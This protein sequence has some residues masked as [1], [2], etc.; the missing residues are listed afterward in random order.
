MRK[1]GERQPEPEPEPERQPEP[2]P[3]PQ[4]QPEPD[5]ESDAESD[6]D[7]DA[8]SGSGSGSESGA[9]AGTG[10]GERTVEPLVVARGLVKHFPVGGG[11]LGRTRWLRA[12]DGVSFEVGRGETVALVGESGSGK[13]TAGRLVL[14]LLEAT[15]GE[16]FFDGEPIFSAP[17]ARLRELRREMQ[18]IFQ[19]PFGSLNPRHTVEAI[20]GEGL[21]TK[22]VRSRR[23]RRDLAAAALARVGLDPANHLHRFPHEFSGGQRQ[24]IGIARA[25]VMKPRFIVCDEAVS[26]LDVSVQ[27]QVLNL[28]ARLQ[29]EEGHAYLFIAHDLAV[30][31]HLSDRI[32]VMYLGR[33]VETGPASRI[34]AAPHHPYTR[35]LLASAPADHPRRRRAGA[36][37][38]G[39]IPSPLDP[40]RGC[41]FHTRCPLA[42]DR[43][44]VEDPPPVA[45]GP[46]HTSWCFLPVEGG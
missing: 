2:Q 26:S 41:R 28:L 7:A 4:P 42:M 16:A 15:A 1:A 35:A 17:A 18:V 9:G 23:A 33:I 5:A 43:C 29:A 8:G 30:V 13:T 20:V 38:A 31:R 25:L 6:A 24:R 27:A 40:P 19:D 14:R 34:F 39:D 10:T 44:R 46:G 12:V 37:L 11:I 32:A 3:Q 36:A 21:I 45:A 22:G